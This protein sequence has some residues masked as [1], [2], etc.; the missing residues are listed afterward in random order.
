MTGDAALSTEKI[1]GAFDESSYR[2]KRTRDAYMVQMTVI[3]NR[4]DSSS[5]ESVCETHT[6]ILHNL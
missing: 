1:F 4:I 5:P 3:F 2:S 6:R